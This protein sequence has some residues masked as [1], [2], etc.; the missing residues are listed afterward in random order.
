MEDKSCSKEKKKKKNL[1][2]LLLVT[3]TSNVPKV[4]SNNVLLLP[5]TLRTEGSWC[6]LFR[7]VCVSEAAESG[8]RRGR[9]WS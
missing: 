1:C 3:N 9:E 6:I 7:A 8:D 5:L 4:I 2:C